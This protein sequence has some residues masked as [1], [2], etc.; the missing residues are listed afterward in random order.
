MPKATACCP[1]GCCF[2][3]ARISALYLPGSRPACL[4][5]IHSA[6]TATH[7]NRDADSVCDSSGGEHKAERQLDH[8]EHNGLTVRGLIHFILGS[9]GL[10]AEGGGATWVSRITAAPIT[11]ESRA[12]SQ[13]LR[14]KS[15]IAS[16]YSYF[17]SSGDFVGIHRLRHVLVPSN[18]A[19]TRTSRPN[20]E[21]ISV[22]NGRRSEVDFVILVV[23][24]VLHR[25]EAA[26]EIKERDLA[27]KGKS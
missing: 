27:G 18:V 19:R 23:S 6:G 7:R 25:N 24:G 9:T 5:A 26:M 4:S 11:Q 22:G 17:S 10:T 13:E 1:S 2:P 21:L 14:A 20:A 12:K 16:S 3:C 15:S 8:K